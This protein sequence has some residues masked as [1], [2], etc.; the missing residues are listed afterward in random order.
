M[1]Y[2][3]RNN[4]NPYNKFVQNIRTLFYHIYLY[5]SHGHYCI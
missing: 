2:N 4:A 3:K 5:I 1:E